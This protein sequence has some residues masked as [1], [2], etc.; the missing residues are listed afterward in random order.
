MNTFNTCVEPVPKLPPAVVLLLAV[1]KILLPVVVET[2]ALLISL[3][4]FQALIPWT[5]SVKTIEN[6]VLAF[7]VEP[8]PAPDPVTLI[9]TTPVT[10]LLAQ[11]EVPPCCNRYGYGL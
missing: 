2:S 11:E 1:A 7:P 9:L 4:V 10:A 8:V 5:P 6:V 3:S